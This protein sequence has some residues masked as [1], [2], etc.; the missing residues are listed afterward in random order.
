MSG[1]V[2]GQESRPRP[3]R[4]DGRKQVAQ[5]RDRTGLPRMQSGVPGR[6]RQATGRAGVGDQ[7]RTGNGGQL[8]RTRGIP[9]RRRSIVNHQV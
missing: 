2:H 3:T 4:L 6:T 9:G 7:G 1:C 5:G 8:L